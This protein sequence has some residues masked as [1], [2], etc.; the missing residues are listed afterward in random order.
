MVRVVR[1][2][3]NKVTFAIGLREFRCAERAQIANPIAPPLGSPH[4][5]SLPCFQFVCGNRNDDSRIG[6]WVIYDR[7]GGRRPNFP[8]GRR[9]FSVAR[10]AAHADPRRPCGTGPDAMG[11]VLSRTG[12]FDDTRC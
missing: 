6:L 11:R 1:Y 10:R 2:L 3:A 7:I 9:G 12:Q 4:C 8:P 5:L